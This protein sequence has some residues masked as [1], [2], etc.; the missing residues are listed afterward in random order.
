MSLGMQREA[1]NIE[2]KSIHDAFYGP[3]LMPVQ[4]TEVQLERIV[5]RDNFFKFVFV[6]NPTDRMLSCFLDRVRKP[7]SVPYNIVQEALKKDPETE[8]SFTEFVEFVSTQSVKEMNPHWRPQYH[9]CGYEM[10]KYD[11]VYKF[12][13]I[14]EGIDDFLQRLYPQQ[15]AKID[16]SSNYSPART[17]ASQKVASY[18]TERD[19]SLI[20][21]I[22]AKD[23]E[24][25]GYE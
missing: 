12:E 10:I 15:A 5:S 8:V 11:K 22:Y 1:A 4:I 13:K 19:Q 16:T 6:R 9:E 25:F 23:F 3:L 21:D 17:D 20:H 18:V 2:L 14:G 7:G 24:A